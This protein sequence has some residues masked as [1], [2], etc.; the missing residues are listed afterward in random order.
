M[1][2]GTAVIVAGAILTASAP[3]LAAFP[4]ATVEGITSERKLPEL[5]LGVG[6]DQTYERASISREF[7]EGGAGGEPREFREL[8]YE[9]IRR[10]LLIQARMGIVDD[11][12]L[13]ITAPIVLQNDSS[14]AFAE[15][16]EGNST[17]F[18]SMN[19]D[20]PAFVNRFPISTVPQERSRAGFGDLSAGFFWSPVT[21][22]PARFWPTVT[23]GLEVTF[24]TGDPWDPADVSALPDQS[25]TGGIGSGHTTFDFSLGLSKRSAWG[26]P[27]FDPYFLVGFEMPV[28][29]S[30]LE[31]FGYDPALIGRVLAGSEIVF[32][33]DQA[34][35][36]YYG[37]DV[38]FTLRFIGAARTRSPLSDYLPD[39]DQ[40]NVDA[41]LVTRADFANPA[42]YARFD[43]N[44]DVSCATGADGTP[45]LPGVP[46]GEFTRVE[47]H[48][49]FDAHLGVRLQP[50]KWVTILAGASIGFQNDHF[51][52]GEDAGE[53]LDPANPAS[54]VCG[55]TS[56]SGRINRSNSEGVDERSRH[57]DPRYDAPGGRFRAERVLRVGAFA[58]AVVQF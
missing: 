54:D 41:D 52:T 6:F 48:M 13:R 32:S 43:P 37:L 29:N 9:S 55:S 49:Q 18:G 20:D 30:E 40:T 39:F 53:D 33:E 7:V 17:I 57:F 11:F 58:T 5:H 2:G 3:A 10:E 26:A 45:L 42:N 36:R 50:S 28:V 4:V 14:I 16:V 34:K 47:Q 12:E 23:L 31:D 25:G 8:E 22:E 44:L 19:A 27:A 15:G 46:C 1:N 56:C 51:I 38:G 35:D 24:P 21:D